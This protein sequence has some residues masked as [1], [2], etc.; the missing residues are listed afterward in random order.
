MV[1]PRF[2]TPEF[3]FNR[4]RS[5]MVVVDAGQLLSSWLTLG[6]LF[7]S[8]CTGNWGA[9]FIWGGATLIGTSFFVAASALLTPCRS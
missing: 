4:S 9:C 7:A 1:L 3:F 6:C 2:G 8:L 5:F